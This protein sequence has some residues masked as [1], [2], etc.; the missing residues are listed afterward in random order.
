M[1]R[2]RLQV[3]GQ[4]L[5]LEATIVAP[6]VGAL[7][8]AGRGISEQFTDHVRKREL[9]R[10]HTTSCHEGCSACCEHLVPISTIEAV[11]LSSVVDTL[12]EPRRAA[13]KRRFTDVASRLRKAGMLDPDRRSALRAPAVREGESLWDA[14]SR[15]YR[16]LALPCP[17]LEAR[18]C[19]IYED[20]PLV[21]R[22]YAVTS[23]PERCAHPRSEGVVAL[24][25]PVRMSEVLADTMRG[26]LP[27]DAEDA[28]SIPLA[29]T[30]WWVEAHGAAVRSTLATAG[31]D[32]G[33]LVVDMIDVEDDA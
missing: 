18:R 27:P 1:P 3:L 26:L 2:R 21:C 12:P 23:P 30:L 13:V 4:P 6:S 14:T 9:A 8:E 5:D 7:F 32:V 16:E 19:S 15:R 24:P 10:G 11:H 17:F 20:R 22:E 29:L 33:Q 28:T 31:S 25:R